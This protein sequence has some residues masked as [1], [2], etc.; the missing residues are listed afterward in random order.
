M[1]LFFFAALLAAPAAAFVHQPPSRWAGRVAL[2]ST[3]EIGG[4][5]S[6][7]AA[8]IEFYEGTNEPD[9]PDVKLTRSKDG[10]NGVAT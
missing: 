8:R 2:S 3:A 4:S 6:P 1:R 7:A 9:I 10:Q 5:A